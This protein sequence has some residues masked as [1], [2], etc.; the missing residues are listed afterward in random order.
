[1]TGVL[2]EV[3]E[4]YEA[5]DP[6]LRYRGGRWIM[7]R[8]WYD[9]IRAAAF[10][11]EQE[12]IRADAHARA[13]VPVLADFPLH[14]PACPSGPFEWPGLIEHVRMMSDPLNR[15]PGTAD[16]LFGLPILVREEG[17]APHV[18]AAL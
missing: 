2:N 1:M 7:D 13:I 9:R 15:E 11:E 8:G 18:E 10:T 14:C 3:Y 12:R 17:G 6:S 16:V 4:A 5:A